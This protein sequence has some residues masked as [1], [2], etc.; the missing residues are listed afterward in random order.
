[1]EQPPVRTRPVE[2]ISSDEEERIRSG[3]F[4]TTHF[5]FSPAV[6][7]KRAEVKSKEGDTLLE[8]LCAPAA[9]IWRVNHGWRQGNHDGFSIEPQTGRWGRRDVDLTQGEEEGREELPITGVKPFVT[10][11][12]NLLLIRPTVSDQSEE[13]LVTLLYALKRGIQF[14]HQV[15]EQEVAAELI[16]QNE[17]RRLMFWEAAEGGTGVSELLME[18]TTAIARIANQALR[19]CHFNPE[20]GQEEGLGG[21]RQCTVACYECLLSY[22]NQPEH[23][24][25]DRRLVRDFLLRLASST[26]IVSNSRNRNQQYEW[27]KSITDPKSGLEKQFLDFIFNAGYRLP[28]TAQ[29]R[30]CAEVPAQ[31]DFYYG[32]E[33]VPGTCVF[34]DGSSHKHP[35]AAERD[36]K[37]R[38]ALEDH[39]YRVIAINFDRE[40]EEQIGQHPDV[41]G[42]ISQ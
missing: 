11:N 21:R 27:L 1:M 33:G 13:F 41:F 5:C 15:E 12:R 32:T 37:V 38:K 19:I 28:D 4:V 34:I 9:R 29:N 25:L 36:E 20:T 30:P 31:P 10:D 7:L 26:T 16:G 8:I 18:D 23:R 39:G 42:V 22:T 3:Y 40:L 2:R 14:V 35:L 24:L 6:Q 17:H